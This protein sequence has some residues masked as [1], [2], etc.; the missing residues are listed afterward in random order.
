MYEEKAYTHLAH[1]VLSEMGSEGSPLY[2]AT[3]SESK[4][5]GTIPVAAVAQDTLPNKVTPLK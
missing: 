5:V 3:Y 2:N 1:S 4:H